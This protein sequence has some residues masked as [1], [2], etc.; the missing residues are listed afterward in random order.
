[1]DAKAT[2][3]A[4]VTMAATLVAAVTA[5]AAMKKI[6]GIRRGESLDHVFQDAFHRAFAPALR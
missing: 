3:P 1:M 4:T 6:R 5:V 2:V